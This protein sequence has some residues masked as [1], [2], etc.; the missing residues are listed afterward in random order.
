MGH[1][2]LEPE[3]TGPEPA[4]S[5]ASSQGASGLEIQSTVQNIQL[6]PI[7][8]KATAGQLPQFAAADDS[9]DNM[10]LPGLN[11]TLAYFK[12]ILKGG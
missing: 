3:L 10:N 9:L 1:A 6:L 4:E 12:D 5:L 8:A 7:V 11:N 2:P